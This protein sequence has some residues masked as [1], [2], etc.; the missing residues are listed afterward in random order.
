MPA[1]IAFGMAEG[2]MDSCAFCHRKISFTVTHLPENID[3]ETL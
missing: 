2:G 3:N 1:L